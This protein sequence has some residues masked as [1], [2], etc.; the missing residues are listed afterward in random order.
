MNAM[1]SKKVESEKATDRDQKQQVL[2]KPWTQL[3]LPWAQTNVQ[4]YQQPFQNQ[5]F[6]PFGFFMPWIMMF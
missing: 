1:E 4:Y 3:P 6:Q 2:P 5:N